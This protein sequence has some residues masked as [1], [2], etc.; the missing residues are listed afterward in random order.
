MQ[1]LL[2]SIQ[3]MALNQGINPSLCVSS[4]ENVKKKVSGVASGPKKGDRVGLRS[5]VRL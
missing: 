5:N 3:L 2:V 4:R 1:N